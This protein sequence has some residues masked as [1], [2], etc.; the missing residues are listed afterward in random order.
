ME[1]AVAGAIIVKDRL[2]EKAGYDLPTLL[3][4][5]AVKSDVFNAPKQVP[6]IASILK[7]GNARIAGV[8]GGVAINSWIIADKAKTS[9]KVA[10]VRT[11][12]VFQKTAGWW[13]N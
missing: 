3:N 10:I 7:K 11:K 13:Q 6:T 4:S 9:D 2:T 12:A 5:P 8:S 1:L